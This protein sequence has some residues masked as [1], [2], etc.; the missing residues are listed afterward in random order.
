MLIILMGR[1]GEIEV[2]SLGKL[3]FE[4]G[5]YAYVGSAQ[6]NLEKRIAR[7][8]RR[9]KKIFWHIDYLLSD[10]RARIIK[11]LFKGAP[12]SEECRLAM[13]LSS[14]YRPVEG[15]G[16]SDCKCPGHLFKL[17]GYTDIET[18]LKEFNMSLLEVERMVG[19]PRVGET[20]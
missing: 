7:H 3:T 4:K 19:A 16:S 10:E 12:K 1:G 6:N 14:L 5:L 17:N 13:A 20:K 2:G 15:F 8:F 11:V 18:L 9:E